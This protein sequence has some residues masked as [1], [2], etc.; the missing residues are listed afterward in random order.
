MKLI[1]AIVNKK[2]AGFVGD[3]LR[4]K[5]I[6]YTKIATSGGFLGS[7]NVTLLIGVQDEDLEKALGEIRKH[8]KQRTEEI[9]SFPVTSGGAI[10]FNYS[11]V[12]VAV[13]GATIFVTPVEKFE[14]I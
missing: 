11:T 8:C 7:G 2:D 3:A 12:K 10:G 4:E 14:K 5:G 6:Y 13:G 9:P 1:T